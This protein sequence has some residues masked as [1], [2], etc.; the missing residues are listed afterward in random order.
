MATVVVEKYLN[1]KGEVFIPVN[2]DAY[3]SSPMVDSKGEY[4]FPIRT[5]TF[6]DG[7]AQSLLLALT[8]TTYVAPP[9]IEAGNPYG[10]LL[11]LTYPA[12]P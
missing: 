9:A 2:Q 6:E 8:W 3:N 5:V 11:G 1:T 10:L 12:T 7:D 4:Y